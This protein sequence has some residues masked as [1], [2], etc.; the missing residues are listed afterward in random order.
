MRYP[1]L[2]EAGSDDTAFGVAVP[3]LARAKGQSRGSLTA[4]LT[5][6]AR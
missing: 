5:L 2:I 6:S 3:D 1:I 4:H